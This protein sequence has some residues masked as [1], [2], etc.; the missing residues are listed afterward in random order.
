MPRL[1]QD[2]TSGAA[3]IQIIWQDQRLDV[4]RLVFRRGHES[5]FDATVGRLAG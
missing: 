5:A 1:A 2:K 4:R 3:V